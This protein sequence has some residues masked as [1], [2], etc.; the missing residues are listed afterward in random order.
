VYLIEKD[1]KGEKAVQRTVKAGVSDHGETAVQGI[2]AGDDVAD[3]SFEKLQNGSQVT[4][5]KVQIPNTA[6]TSAG[7][8]P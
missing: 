3:S 8:A 5:S 1:A 2:K 4:R 7:T 6:E